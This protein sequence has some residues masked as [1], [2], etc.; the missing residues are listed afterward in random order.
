MEK[1]FLKSNFSNEDEKVKNTFGRV[2]SNNFEA[3]SSFTLSD[4]VFFETLFYIT[5]TRLEYICNNI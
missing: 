5:K 1:V 3:T 2:F 4:W